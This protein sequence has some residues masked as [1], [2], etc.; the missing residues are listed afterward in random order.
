VC[1]NRSSARVIPRK[2]RHEASATTIGGESESSSFF[3][4][5]SSHARVAPRIRDG[6]NGDIILRAR[7]RTR[8][9]TMTRARAHTRMSDAHSRHFSTRVDTRFHSSDSLERRARAM[10]AAEVKVRV[11]GTRGEKYARS[12]R[13]RDGT[14]GRARTRVETRGSIARPG[15]S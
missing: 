10:P 14:R 11:R 4:I 2:G 13:A 3:V 5:A 15:V 8:A 1:R 12:I 9:A 7:A 6:T